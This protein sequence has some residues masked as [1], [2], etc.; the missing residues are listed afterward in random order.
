MTTTL[1]FVPN[2]VADVTAAGE[3]TILGDTH[4]MW[5]RRLTSDIAD[6]LKTPTDSWMRCVVEGL[7]S[8]QT[9]AL[10]GKGRKP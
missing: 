1:P 10:L 9:S 4:A 2:K 8:Y 5:R 7:L 6:F 3:D